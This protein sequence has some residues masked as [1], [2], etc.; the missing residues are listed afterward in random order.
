VGG[1]GSV[2]DA[3][4][5]VL[6]GRNESGVRTVI[7]GVTDTTTIFLNEHKPIFAVRAPDFFVAHLIPNAFWISDNLLLAPSSRPIWKTKNISE[8]INGCESGKPYSQSDQA[9]V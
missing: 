4:M 5:P 1:F 8:W 6:L 2:F 7:T 3:I 9:S